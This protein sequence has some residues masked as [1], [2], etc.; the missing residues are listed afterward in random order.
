MHLEIGTDYSMMRDLGVP[1]SAVT[2]AENL[3]KR[4][5]SGEVAWAPQ[6]RELLRF[7]RQVEQRGEK[8][9]LR[10]LIGSAP[11]DDREVVAEVLGRTFGKP[12][13]KPLAL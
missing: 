6:A 2:A 10:N 8:I 1:D 9:A 5:Q 11:E 13:I 12:K 3:E 4:R 7:M